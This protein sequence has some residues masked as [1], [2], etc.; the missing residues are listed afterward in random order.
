MKIL[1]IEPEY[2]GCFFWKLNDAGW[3]EHFDD[4]TGCTLSAALQRM[5]KEWCSAFDSTFDDDDPRDSGFPSPEA[6]STWERQGLHLRDALAKELG[7]GWRVFYARPRCLQDTDRCDLYLDRPLP[8][9]WKRNR[10]LPMNCRAH[11]HDWNLEVNADAQLPVFALRM[12]GKLVRQFDHW[13]ACW[14]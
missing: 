7:G 8:W 12:D 11:G 13:P 4:L 14:K 6:E 2:L 1:K 10:W 3:F 5:M 9:V